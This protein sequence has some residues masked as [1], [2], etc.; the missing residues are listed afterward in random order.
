MHPRRLLVCAFICSCHLGGNVVST[1][2]VTLA[3]MTSSEPAVTVKD[4]TL[5]ILDV[6]DTAAT[7][8]HKVH[9]LG[10]TA[11]GE[12]LQRLAAGYKYSCALDGVVLTDGFTFH[13]NGP[14]DNR[15]TPEIG[16]IALDQYIRAT[17]SAE[18]SACEFKLALRE[19]GPLSPTAPPEYRPLGTLCLSNGDKPTLAEGLCAE[20]TLARNPPSPHLLS[21]RPL[22]TQAITMQPGDR[23]GLTLGTLLTLNGTLPAEPLSVTFK[24]T[25]DGAE[26][27]TTLGSQHFADLA[28]GESIWFSGNLGPIEQTTAPKRCDILVT[29]T[30]GDTKDA[31]IARACY[32]GAL[33]PGACA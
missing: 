14:V 24:S 23:P 2:R 17:G 15:V 26:G 22:S 10:F 6:R 1:Q 30:T 21:A 28:P 8:T 3:T 27:T 5:E 9:S 16:M 4:I 31:E 32:D 29:L 25:C 20:A 33:K 18:P 11:E 7:T 12:P 19:R 13:G